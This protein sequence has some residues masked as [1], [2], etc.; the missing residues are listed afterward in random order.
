MAKFLAI[1]DPCIAAARA[2]LVV[3]YCG[4]QRLGLLQALAAYGGGQII[5]RQKASAAL[6]AFEAIHLALWFP[7]IE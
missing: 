3:I 4:I 6:R 7:A 5:A 1:D 2:V